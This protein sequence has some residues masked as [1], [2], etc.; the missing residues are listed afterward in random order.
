QRGRGAWLA[1]LA[2]IVRPPAA[3]ALGGVLLMKTKVLWAAAVAVALLGVLPV[4][5]MTESA[6]P[7]VPDTG[8]TAPAV[9]E[10]SIG[11][12]ASEVLAR[13]TV[14]FEGVEAAPPAV[15]SA[16][17]E[18]SGVVLDFDARPVADVRI[19][20][21]PSRDPRSRVRAPVAESGH[22]VSDADGRFTL[23]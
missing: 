12:A 14:D 2:A 9:I 16:A 20:F 21:V 5:R 17:V 6:P 8:N 11:G 7:D 10:P 1:A 23:P 22:V 18:L 13:E 19:V 4:L 3:T 15:E